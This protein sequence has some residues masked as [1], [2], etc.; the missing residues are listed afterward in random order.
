MRI[1]LSICLVLFSL[2]TIAHAAD[3]IPATPGPM[4]QRAFDDL[5]ASYLTPYDPPAIYPALKSLADESPA[6]RAEA[7]QYITALLKQSVIDETRIYPIQNEISNLR[8]HPARHV[9][10]HLADCIENAPPAPELL[11]A[12]LWLIHQD[13]VIEFAP[14][15]AIS[16]VKNPS[17]SA[18]DAYAAILSPAHPSTAVMVT[19]I[20]DIAARKLKIYAPQITAL[21]NDPRSQIRS[22]ARQ[23][24]SA[25][26]IHPIPDFDPATSLTAPYASQLKTF[27][28]MVFHTIPPTASFKHF[29]FKRVPY[30]SI[31]PTPPV[32]YDFPAWLISQNKTHYHVVTL[33]G[34]TDTIPING[35]TVT[36]T[37]IAREAGIILKQNDELR[38]KY[39]SDRPFIRCSHALLAAW[40]YERNDPATAATLLASLLDQRVDSRLITD[41]VAWDI[42]RQ[43]NNL[44][45]RAFLDHDYPLAGKVA[46]HLS[47]DAF[48]H[49]M[50]YA[51]ARALLA[52]L[53]ACTEDF[54]TFTL[55]S[56]EEWSALKQKLD[57][58]ARIKYL[59]D[60]VRLIS[61]FQNSNPG[62]INFYSRQNLGPPH[63]SDI[64]FETYL[65]REKIV[66][67]PIIALHGLDL[68]PADIPYLL[69]AI[70]DQNY[71]YA[72]SLDNADFDS[73]GP[74]CRVSYPIAE[75]IN[76]IAGIELVNLYNYTDAGPARQKELKDGILQ[77]VKDNPHK[78]RAK[79]LPTE[80]SL[81]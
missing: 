52:Q 42:S 74:L 48:R 37:T 4:G 12:Q 5:N 19:V 70:D 22:A 51:Q 63:T 9:H 31:P 6:K 41:A 24:A 26:D 1:P 16:L 28:S 3:A 67:N 71:M 34:D 60:R 30:Q 15:G 75:L 21:C 56:H 23:A 61:A 50:H 10:N 44:M 32:Q 7:A 78:T 66:I 79:N 46:A 13:P 76:N 47:A 40:A 54:N 29:S 14:L 53:P 69:P 33:E 45:S 80:E 35:T 20:N 81:F 27:S 72:Y 62:S 18:R 64:D 49:T 59:L 17:Q 55:P 8:T 11:E 43:Y 68:Q 57:R 77:W 36:D 2:I 25:L 38:R 39:P 65:K 73:Y 58:P